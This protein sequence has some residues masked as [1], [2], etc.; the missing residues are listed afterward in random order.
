MTENIYKRRLVP[1]RPLKDYYIA[2]V[3]SRADRLTISPCIVDEQP[4]VSHHP[5]YIA[6]G[7]GGGYN[8]CLIFVFV[9]DLNIKICWHGCGFR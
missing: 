8:T 4:L 9:V 2:S 1:G 7:G 6:G 5:A 3:V